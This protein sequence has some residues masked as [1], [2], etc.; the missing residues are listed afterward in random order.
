MLW[1]VL[2]HPGERAI[3]LQV[4][5]QNS[6]CGKNLEIQ[7]AFTLSFYLCY[8]HPSSKLLQGPYSI[9]WIMKH[10]NN[11]YQANTL[12]RFL[13]LKGR[14]TC[15][16]LLHTLFEL[17]N[18]IHLWEQLPHRLISFVL[19]WY[20]RR[21]SSTGSYSAFRRSE[22]H[23]YTYYLFALWLAPNMRTMSRS[24]LYF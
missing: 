5:Q 4:P 8:H 1:N 10:T 12:I 11:F 21:V 3:N 17:V 19:P 7:Q 13:Y 23:C 6:V 9:I 22:Y 14:I 15:P 24:V 18:V 16:H 20:W 2:R